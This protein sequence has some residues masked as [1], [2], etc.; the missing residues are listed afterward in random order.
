MSLM[1][2]EYL[3]CKQSRNSAANVIHQL[4]MGD[5]VEGA[6]VSVIVQQ[7]VKVFQ[8]KVSEATQV[9]AA[10]Q[11]IGQTPVTNI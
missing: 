3:L 5:H 8:S 10:F 1:V 9:L 4:V 6:N 7:D 2:T 11:A